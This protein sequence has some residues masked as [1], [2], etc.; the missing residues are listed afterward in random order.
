[1]RYIKLED[2]WIVQQLKRVDLFDNSVTE[3]I[4]LHDHD[5]V[6]GYVKHRYWMG[7]EDG[8]NPPQ[9]YECETCLEVVPDTILGFFN[10][11]KW[12]K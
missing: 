11:C 3:W 9:G 7:K 8:W 10:L 6:E 12:E 2:G 4:L 1:M 5:P